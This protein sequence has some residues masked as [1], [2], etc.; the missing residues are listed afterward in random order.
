MA[1]LQQVSGHAAGVVTVYKEALEAC[2][3]HA[4]VA[5]SAAKYFIE[6]VCV[7]FCLN[8]FFMREYKIDCIVS[9]VFRPNFFS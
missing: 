7:H 6:T 1:A 4:Q 2:N 8:F 3:K 9:L 5:Y